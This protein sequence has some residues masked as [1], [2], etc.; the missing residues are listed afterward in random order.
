MGGAPRILAVQEVELLVAL[1]CPG[2]A[3]GSSVPG[4]TGLQVLVK[5]ALWVVGS[6]AG[7]RLESAIQEMM[8]E[9]KGCSREE[10]FQLSSRLLLTYTRR[11]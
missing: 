9:W 10:G 7:H 1:A 3:A 8:A 2:A 4:N 6:G 11:L 5:E